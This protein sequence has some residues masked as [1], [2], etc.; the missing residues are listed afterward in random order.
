MKPALASRENPMNEAF[1]EADDGAGCPV[2][3]EAAGER[4]LL[5]DLWP[6]PY[7]RAP[8]SE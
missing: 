1:A 5:E 8:A 4:R 2:G 7:S 3:P 6:A